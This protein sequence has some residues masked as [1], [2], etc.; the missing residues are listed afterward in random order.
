MI[1][2][3]EA[4]T[5]S[6]CKSYEGEK[7]YPHVLLV[8]DDWND[9]YKYE[10]L[11]R[12]YYH[13]DE[14]HCTSIGEVKILCEDYS[15]Y[16][17]RHHMLPFFRKLD[18]TFCSLG[19][20]VDYYYK[21]RELPTHIV[22]HILSSLNDITLKPDISDN[23]KNKEGI[24]SSLRR[25]S[26]AD[27]AFR[28]AKS[29]LEGTTID[30]VLKF[31]FECSIDNVD[32]PHTVNFD[33]TPHRYLPYRINA[34]V[35]KNATGKTKVLSNLASELSGAGNGNSK[36][37]DD[38]RPSFR[39]YIAISYS[40]FDDFNK[41]FN[42]KIRKSSCF[43][44]YIQE[45][46][47]IIPQVI[48]EVKYFEGDNKSVIDQI[49]ILNENIELI[50]KETYYKETL[51]KTKKRSSNTLFSYVY[52]GLRDLSGIITEERL[53]DRFVLSYEEIISK[54][55]DND[56]K[57]FLNYII[58]D[59]SILQE[60]DQ[61]IKNKEKNLDNILGRLSSGQSIM[62]YIITELIENIDQESLLLFDEPEIHLHPNAISNFMRMFNEIL[63]QYNSYAVI[64]T[65]SPLIIQEIPSNYVRLF[66][67]NSDNTPSI[68][69][70]Y[71]ESFGENI[72]NITNN[73]FD[74]LDKESNYKDYLRKFEV[75]SKD[76]II[77]L[78]ENGLSFNS[79]TYLNTLFKLREGQK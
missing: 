59:N 42:Q 78:F 41:P 72:S 66:Q 50:E 51:Y 75:L 65:H 36:F 25:F 4:F 46:K 26:D 79:L 70:L 15:K 11:F 30:K 33:F 77:D 39:K 13:E 47:K 52:C 53:K 2:Y 7:E 49:E 5:P 69:K 67:K 27:K 54:N 60:I 35:G 18:T 6:H 17:T 44:D 23:F 20:S 57:K 12:A 31:T 16:K 38:A 76:E 40:A 45:V 43:I 48:N 1:F 74:V 9:Y 56:W 21:L 22:N 37:Y 61:C 64:S 62:L 24:Y 68:I 3:L 10:T 29:I 63:D 28:E 71:E 8:T 32:E 58:D 55:R 34:L 19:Q 14:N 73:I